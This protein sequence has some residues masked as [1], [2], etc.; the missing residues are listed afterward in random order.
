VPPSRLRS[1]AVSATV[2]RRLVEPQKR[3]HVRDDREPPLHY[4]GILGR[5]RDPG[6]M[7]PSDGTA[8]RLAAVLL[9]SVVVGVGVDVMPVWAA[10]ANV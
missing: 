8:R 1:R 3:R 5:G 6:T 9:A 2:Q 7:S 10:Q 4:R